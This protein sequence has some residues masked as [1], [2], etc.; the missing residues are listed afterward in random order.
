MATTKKIK[1]KKKGRAFVLYNN[2][3][4]SRLVCWTRARRSASM[5]VGSNYVPYNVFYSKSSSSSISHILNYS[6]IFVFLF[7]SCERVCV[8]CRKNRNDLFIS[9]VI[10]KPRGSSVYA[11]VCNLNILPTE[12]EGRSRVGTFEC[13]MGVV[14]SRLCRCKS[15]FSLNTQRNR[16]RREN[17]YGST[18]LPFAW[19]THT[20]F[21]NIVSL[22]LIDADAIQWVRVGRV[23]ISIENLLQLALQRRL[24]SAVHYQSYT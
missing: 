3:P 7:F 19:H 11:R 4:S 15:F 1:N 9:C 21:G 23:P 14:E 2:P 22:F 5:S 13:Y 24:P 17:R 10:H 16:R 12:K 18:L 8:P 20:I 6:V